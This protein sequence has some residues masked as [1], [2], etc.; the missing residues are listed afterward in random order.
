MTAIL[1]IGCNCQ[2]EEDPSNMTCLE[3]DQDIP[4]FWAFSINSAC[5]SLGRPKYSISDTG[6]YNLTQELRYEL[7][8]TNSDLY[9]PVSLISTTAVADHG[10]LNMGYWS[11]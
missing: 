9:E 4:L 1:R 6:L 7:N 10:K 11:S 5:L 8:S 2:V 3:E